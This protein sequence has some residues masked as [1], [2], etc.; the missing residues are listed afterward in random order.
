MGHRQI[1]NMSQNVLECL[2]GNEHAMKLGKKLGAF[3][4]KS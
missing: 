3:E 1:D 2:E 4:V